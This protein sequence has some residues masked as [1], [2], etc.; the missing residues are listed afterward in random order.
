M[1]E[2]LL[3]E[4]SLE[5]PATYGVNQKTGMFENGNSQKRRVGSGSEDYLGEHQFSIEEKACPAASSRDFSAI[6]QMKLDSAVGSN[7]GP[8]QG[9][10]G[11]RC[12]CSP[13][14][15]DTLDFNRLPASAS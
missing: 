6:G 11:Q 7:F 5:Q 10:R 9:N 13:S 15:N 4:T 12:E 1:N 3:I 2:E 14:V 8:G